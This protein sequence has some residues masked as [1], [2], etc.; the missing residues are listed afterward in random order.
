MLEDKMSNDL[1]RL[2]L[3][4]VNWRGP[5]LPLFRKQGGYWTSKGIGELIESAIYM[6]VTTPLGSRFMRP[7]FGSYLPSLVFEPDDDVLVAQFR[8]YTVE[9]IGDPVHGEPRVRIIDVLAIIAEN[10]LRV[11]LTYIILATGEQVNQFIQMSRGTAA[12]VLGVY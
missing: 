6:I 5:A 3:S 10:A 7:E 8:E 11:R 12:S 9:A 4:A 1:A 2:D